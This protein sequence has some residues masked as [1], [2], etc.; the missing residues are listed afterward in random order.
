[1]R[2]FRAVASAPTPL[3]R[4]N[5]DTDQI[6]PK[7]FLKLVDRTGF[8]RHLFHNWRYAGAGGEG[9]RPDPSFV[10]NDPLYAGS[11]ILVA[12]DNFGC[13]SSREHAVWALLDY[14][15]DVVIAPSFADIF[16][17]NC[18]K[19]GLLPVALGRAHVDALLAAASPPGPIPRVAVDLEAQTVEAGCIG[20]V[21]FEIR[22][23]RRAA[24][25]GGL[26]EIDL[27]VRQYG[28]AISLFERGPAAPPSALRSRRP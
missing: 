1:M 5:I 15:F 21:R 10:L 19:N 7:Q 6:V 13:G 8:G 12:G 17:G 28:G 22:A 2:P 9:G 25:L 16:Y 3:G 4:V 20:T 11:R 26:D 27:T 14:G 18:F 23:D 24:L